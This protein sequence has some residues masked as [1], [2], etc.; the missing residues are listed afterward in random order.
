MIVGLREFSLREFLKKNLDLMT[1][2]FAEIGL[3]VLVMLLSFA[4]CLLILIFS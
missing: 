1:G 4:L 2:I 3:T